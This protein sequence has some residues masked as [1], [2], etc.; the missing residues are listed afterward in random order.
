VLQEVKM[1]DSEKMLLYKE[2]FI[3]YEFRRVIVR[4]KD[5]PQ[6]IVCKSVLERKKGIKMHL[7]DFSKHKWQGVLKY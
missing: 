7:D 1:S 6:W 4:G 2:E 3:K 5:R